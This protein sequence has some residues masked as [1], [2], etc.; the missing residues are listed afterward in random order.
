MLDDSEFAFYFI[1]FDTPYVEHGAALARA[2]LRCRI[3]EETQP[4]FDAARLVAR[5]ARVT[6]TTLVRLDA[7][8]K[9]GTPSRVYDR[10][11]QPLRYPGQGTERDE[12]LGDKE[13]LFPSLLRAIEQFGVLENEN[14]SATAEELRESGHSD[15]VR[16][17]PRQRWR[18]RPRRR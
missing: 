15:S 5:E 17:W 16:P 13:R 8:K 3:K 14:P 7:K 1:D 4:N 12:E 2:W 11:S 18:P 10:R 6:A 9:K